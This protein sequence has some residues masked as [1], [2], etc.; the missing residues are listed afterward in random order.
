MLRL[1]PS[2]LSLAPV[3][4]LAGCPSDDDD[5]DAADDT[6]GTTSASA[7]DAESTASPTSG[8][9]ADDTAGQDDSAGSS[10]GSGGPDL[11][12]LYACEETDL[13]VVQPFVGPGFDETGALLEPVAD[14]Y[15]VSTTQLLPRPEAEAQ[16]LFNELT[17]AVVAQV[18]QTPG[19]VGVAVATEPNCGF[20]RTLSVWESEEAMFAFVGSGAHAEAMTHTF[21]VGVTGR[22]TSWSVPGEEAPP[23]WETAIAQIAEVDPI[24]GY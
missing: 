11:A 14:E 1:L 6:G 8:E 19:F 7:D 16:Q 17:G 13:V 3:V 2:L 18:M 24:G 23:S 20:A 4:L 22:V 10:G 12:E 5:P 9:P 21:D 15:V